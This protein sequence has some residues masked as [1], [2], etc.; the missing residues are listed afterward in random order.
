[1]SII[2]YY[3][4]PTIADRLSTMSFLKTILCNLDIYKYT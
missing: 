4:V 3:S 1:M 2:Q